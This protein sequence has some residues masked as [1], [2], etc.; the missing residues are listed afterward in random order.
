LNSHPRFANMGQDD[1][2]DL[3]KHSWTSSAPGTAE[4]IYRHSLNEQPA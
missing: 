4:G 3:A 2:R 1:Y